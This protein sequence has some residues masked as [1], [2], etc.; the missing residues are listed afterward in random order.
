MYCLLQVVLDRLFSTK[1]VSEERGTLHQ[2]HNLLHRTAVSID[3]ESCRRL[4]LLLVL[5]A[6]VVA[7]AKGL[8]DSESFAGS[9]PSPLDVARVMVDTHHQSSDGSTDG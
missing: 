3:H 2:I 5:Y 1:S 8:L 4:F 7:G 6:H 9:S